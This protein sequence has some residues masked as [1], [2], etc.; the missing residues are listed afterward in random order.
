MVTN[1]RTTETTEL[2]RHNKKLRSLASQLSLAEENKRRRI[3]I[4]L[5]DRTNETLIYSI[6]KLTA[7]TK[8]VPDPALV[9]SLNEVGQL[10]QQLAQET[11]LLTFE[12]SPPSLYYLGLEATVKEL[13][14]RMAEKHGLK[15]SFKDDSLSKPTDADVS[16]LLFQSVRE[17]LAN[18][19]KHSQVRTV[20]VNI[21]RSDDNIQITVQDD[22]IGFDASIINSGKKAEGFGLF[23]IRERM[24]HVGGHLRIESDDRGSR[25]TLLVPL[26][27]G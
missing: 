22:G 5:H 20:S 21:C 10:L 25:I 3:A 9:E 13:T 17:L 15:A 18:V 11:R 23:C 4:E 26:R 24:H 12:L 14:D 7:L 6:I 27:E 1:R 16:V 8:S 2:E 19:T